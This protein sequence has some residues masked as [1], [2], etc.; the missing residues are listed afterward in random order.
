M[1]EV[2][3]VE[4]HRDLET[5]TALG[6]EIFER[7]GAG[8]TGPEFLEV[9]RAQAAKR[10]GLRFVPESIASWDHRKLAGVY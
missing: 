4:F 8:Q 5:V 6:T 2:A 3:H 7:Y 10:V 1:A 9:V